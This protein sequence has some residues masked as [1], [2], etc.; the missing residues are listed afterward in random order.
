MSCFDAVRNDTNQSPYK[1]DFSIR[2][3]RSIQGFGLSPG[4]TKEQRVGVENL[5]KGACQKFSGETHI[6]MP[7]MNPTVVS[8]NRRENNAAVILDIRVQSPPEKLFL[9]CMILPPSQGRVHAT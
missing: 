9:G 6:I 8:E 7:S 4:I 1:T 2:V 5:F 3:G